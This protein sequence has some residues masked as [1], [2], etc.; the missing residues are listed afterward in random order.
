ME[1]IDF[2][3]HLEPTVLAREKLLASMERNGVI[4][5]AVVAGRVASPK[6]LSRNITEGG[7]GSFP[8]PNR[9]LLDACAPTLG[10][11]LPFYFANPF[12]ST[13]EYRSIGR[14]FFG[15]KLG[16]AIHGVALNDER[17]LRYI[18]EAASFGHCVYLHCL[19]RPDF[20]I[21]ALVGLLQAF[22]NVPIVLGHAGVGNCDFF[23]VDAIA[24]F[25]NAYFETSG[26]FSSVVRYAVQTL[27]ADRVIF[28]TEYPLQDPCLEILK[29]TVTGLSERRLNE[30]AR[31]LLGFGGPHV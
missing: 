4:Q 6:A 3:A 5:C 16:P 25:P 18:E 12:E 8:V 27:G 31:R 10:K 1:L 17:N 24:P 23:A 15:L 9:E 22:P 30:N 14:Q 7:G 29:V 19:P 13:D 2:H 20:D 28:G 26:G 21:A 11:L